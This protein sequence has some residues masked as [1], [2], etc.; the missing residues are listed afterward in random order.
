MTLEEEFKIETGFD[1]YNEIYLHYDELYV[2]WLENKVDLLR[3]VIIN[4]E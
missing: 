1:S 2:E 3:R 4:K